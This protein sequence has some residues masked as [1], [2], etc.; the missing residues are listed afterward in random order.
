MIKFIAQKKLQNNSN[1]GDSPEDILSNRELEVFIM[2]GKG[3]S[4]HKIASALH[5]SSKTVDTHRDNIKKKLGLQDSFE[6]IQQAI[7]WV[8]GEA[9]E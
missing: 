4:T 7:T 1:I 8:M 5:L 9:I 3:L 6:L 2:L